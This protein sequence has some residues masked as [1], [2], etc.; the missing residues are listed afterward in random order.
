LTFPPDNPT[1]ARIRHK[2]PAIKDE[3]TGAAFPDAEFERLLALQKERIQPG[4]QP[5]TK[6][7]SEASGREKESQHEDHK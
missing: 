5:G 4:L 7:N 3:L 6:P 2:E 1:L